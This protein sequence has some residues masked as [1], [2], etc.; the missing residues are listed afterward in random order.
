MRGFSSGKCLWWRREDR[1]LH[2][3]G[4]VPR[5]VFA[6]FAS[7]WPRQRLDS[8]VG[9]RQN[10]DIYMPLCINSHQVLD[11][12]VSATTVDINFGQEHS[13]GPVARLFA[14][15]GL[16]TNHRD[17]Q[18]GIVGRGFFSPD[19]FTPGTDLPCGA[20]FQLAFRGGKFASRK[21]TPRYGRSP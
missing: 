1:A 9:Q 6:A 4:A 8:A 18:R 3:A 16:A 2:S 14:W 5:W 12:T 20:S 15:A 7:C 21:L 11:R 13:H 19:P 17:A 10:F